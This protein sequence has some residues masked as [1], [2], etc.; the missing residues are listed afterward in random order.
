MRALIQRVEE[1]SV[2]VVDAGTRKRVGSI[3]KGLCVLVGVTHD[4]TTVDAERVADRISHLRVFDDAD[5]VMNLSAS[6][7]SW[8][9]CVDWCM[10]GS[11][12][13]TNKTP[14][15]PYSFCCVSITIWVYQFDD[16]KLSIKWFNPVLVVDWWH[17]KVVG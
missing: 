6:L 5:G 14:D 15:S 8:F 16:V 3:G 11:S 10:N 9:L 12:L 1:A 4:D 7:F 13:L 2:D 17:M